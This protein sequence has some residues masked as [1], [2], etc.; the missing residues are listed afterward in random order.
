M[1]C[2]EVVD[3]GEGKGRVMA[4]NVFER[5]GGAWKLV[6]HHG[7]PAPPPFR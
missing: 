4:T 2:V 3:T 6:L 5:Q 7:S 1:T